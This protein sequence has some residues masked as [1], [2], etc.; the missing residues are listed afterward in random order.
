MVLNAVS[1]IGLPRASQAQGWAGFTNLIAGDCV[2]TLHLFIN[3][4]ALS[5]VLSLALTKAFVA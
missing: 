2:E 1:R 3:S 5:C 4:V